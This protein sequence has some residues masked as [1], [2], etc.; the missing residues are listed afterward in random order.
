MEQGME[1]LVA[2]GRLEFGSSPKTAAL[3]GGCDKGVIMVQDSI[4]PHFSGLSC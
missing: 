2:G 4:V 3:Q 1:N